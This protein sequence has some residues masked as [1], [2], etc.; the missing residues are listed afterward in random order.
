VSTPEAAAPTPNVSIPPEYL[1][2][3]ETRQFLRLR[4]LRQVDKLA[5]T[6]GLPK[7]KVNS[8][9]TL[10]PR[11]GL[12]AWLNEHQATG[13]PLPAPK[14]RRGRPRKPVAR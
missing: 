1:T 9:H 2:R 14:R 5:R 6:A 12:V 11:A 10:Y 7:I 8:T 3:E 4:K 13:N